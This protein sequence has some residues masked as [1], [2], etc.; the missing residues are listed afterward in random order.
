M[1]GAILSAA[2]AVVIAATPLPA[3]VPHGRWLARCSAVPVSAA[4]GITVVAAYTRPRT[5][6]W[7]LAKG[8][9]TGHLICHRIGTYNA[10][11][12]W[13]C[14]GP[15]LLRDRMAADA[16]CSHAIPWPQVRDL[17]T[18]ALQAIASGLVCCGAS[19][20]GQVWRCDRSAALGGDVTVN[21]LDGYGPGV[22][23]AQGP[24]ADYGEV[25]P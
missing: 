17:P 3:T 21:R 24:C 13:A 7:L 19:S 23:G 16:A 2:I 15:L 20:A 1:I 6:A 12:V 18:A 22:V 14:R 9:Q 8:A 11:G 10:V 5:R 25:T 4:D